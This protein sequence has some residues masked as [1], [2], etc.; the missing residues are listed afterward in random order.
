MGILDTQSLLLK[1]P[2]ILR[3][4][5]VQNT[6]HAAYEVHSPM[7]A[8]SNLFHIELKMISDGYIRLDVF[9]SNKILVHVVKS[10]LYCIAMSMRPSS[11]FVRIGIRENLVL[12]V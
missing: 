12:Q 9:V 11:W 6:L 10:R 1:S 8:P 3:P 5:T 7:M 4:K 2:D